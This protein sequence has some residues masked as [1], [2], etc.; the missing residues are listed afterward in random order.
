MFLLLIR[1]HPAL[2][3]LQ[4]KQVE[5]EEAIHILF[6]LQMLKCRKK[7]ELATMGLDLHFTMKTLAGGRIGIASQALGIA[8]GAYELS[9]QLFKTTQSVW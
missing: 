7:I 9:L 6:Y 2:L 4:R 1:I 5:L 3:L 8:S